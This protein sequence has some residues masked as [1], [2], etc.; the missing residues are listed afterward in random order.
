L[1]ILVS[2][3]FGDKKE[4]STVVNVQHF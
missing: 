1:V 3:R 2:Q 4:V